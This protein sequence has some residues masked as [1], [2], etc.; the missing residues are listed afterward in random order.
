[1]ARVWVFGYGSLMWDHGEYKPY[2][3]K[4]AVLEGAHRSFNIKSTRQRGSK[5]HPG[6]VLGLELGG[7]CVGRALLVNEKFVSAID[8]REV[9]HEGVYKKVRTPAL[10]M[11]VLIEGKV[12]ECIVY[13]SNPEHDQYAG[14]LNMAER[15]KLAV[16]AA[17][18]VS[19]TSVDYIRSTKEKLESL[20]VPDKYVEEFWKRIK[21]LG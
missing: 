18:G 9:V 8:K 13:I 14:D 7:V 5:K 17:K 15:V 12:E 21:K 2:E 6:I 19:G 16:S 3:V 10:G 11:K 20:S 1:M 4:T